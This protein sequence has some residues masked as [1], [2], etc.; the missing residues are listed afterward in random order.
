MKIIK[1]KVFKIL[2]ILFGIGFVFGIVSFFITDKVDKSTIEVNLINYIN[3]IKNNDLNYSNAIINTIVQNLKYTSIIWMCG[4]IFIFVI[5]VPLLIIF[6]GILISFTI[7][8]IISVFNIKG[9]L[10]AIIILFPC[11]IIN[12]LVI[13]FMSYY[14]IHFSLKCY[15]AIKHNKYINLKD[16]IKNYSLIYIVL[17][18]ISVINSFIEIYFISN[19]LKFVV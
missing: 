11:T 15:K 17:C 7:L 3:N 16:F 13:L 6:K 12:L 14:S 10:Y 8:N 19:V 18:F 5:I 4:I 1:T 2:L 9:V